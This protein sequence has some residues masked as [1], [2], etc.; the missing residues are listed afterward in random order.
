MQDIACISET[1][2]VQEET[3]NI[4]G[5]NLTRQN[6]PAR[7]ASGGV[8]ISIKKQYTVNEI[9]I[10]N[11]ISLEV[12]CIE[13]NLNNNITLRIIST[14]KQP[15][16]ALQAADF[17]TIFNSQMSTMLI[18]DLNCKSIYWDCRP[19]NPNGNKLNSIT[20]NQNL[21]VLA[22]SEYTYY[23]Y[24]NN[25]LPDILDII[26]CKNCVWPINH[27]VVTELDSDHLPVLITMCETTIPTNTIPRLIN[28]MVD[29][30]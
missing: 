18:G 4:G 26:A 17:I 25:Y 9:Y 22:P 11:T 19:N 8:A 14:Y 7:T 13:L 5:Y 23:P 2:L 12:A 3:F 20:A 28:G 21:Q 27:K 16:K 10:N 1:H 29:W 24:R 30:K 6:R 15:N